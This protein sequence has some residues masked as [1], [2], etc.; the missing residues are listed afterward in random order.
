MSGNLRLRLRLL[1]RFAASTEGALPQ[2]VQISA[3]RHRALLAYLAMQPTYT[4]TRERLATLLW[5]E[6]DQNRRP[7]SDLRSVSSRVCT[8]TFC[9]SRRMA[10]PTFT[11]GRA[12]T[13]SYQRFRFG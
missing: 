8:P 11:A 2:M 6:P 13:A 9:R 10:L 5:G 4:E 7:Y 12:A 1:G 3:P